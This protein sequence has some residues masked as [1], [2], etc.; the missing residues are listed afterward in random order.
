MVGQNGNIAY[1]RREQTAM[2][3]TAHLTT[4]AVSVFETFRNASQRNPQ[5]KYNDSLLGK[6]KIAKPMSI[7]PIPQRQSAMKAGTD[8]SSNNTKEFDV[9]ENA[10]R[11]SGNSNKDSF[12]MV[13]NFC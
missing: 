13:L 6:Q 9:D 12:A 3:N 8:L 4:K 7:K 11:T 2:P 10:L 5:R 1:P